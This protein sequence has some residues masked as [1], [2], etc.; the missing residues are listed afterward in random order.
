MEFAQAW[1]SLALRGTIRAVEETHA[2]SST[3]M[4]P[5]DVP[6]AW[7]SLPGGWHELFGRPAFVGKAKQF[8]DYSGQRSIIQYPYR[9]TLVYGG[10]NW[11]L[12]GCV[13]Q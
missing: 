10:R 6:K 12:Q 1:P 3:D 13:K 2:L 9:T 11:F 5:V 7:C 4:L 8:V